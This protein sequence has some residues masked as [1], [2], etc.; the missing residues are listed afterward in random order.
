MKVYGSNFIEMVQ[1]RIKLMSEISNDVSK[2]KHR[3]VEKERRIY[4]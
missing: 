3:Q 4:L 2:D 1:E